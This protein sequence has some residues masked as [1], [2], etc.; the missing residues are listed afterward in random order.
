MGPGLSLGLSLGLA[1]GFGIG[2]GYVRVR[3]GTLT[4]T[5]QEEAAGGTAP[6]DGFLVE[7]LTAI[8]VFVGLVLAGAANTARV[9]HRRSRRGGDAQRG[10]GLKLPRRRPLGAGSNPDMSPDPTPKAGVG[11][12]EGRRPAV[13]VGS[14]PDATCSVGGVGHHDGRG[15][16]T[17]RSMSG[18]ASATELTLNPNPDP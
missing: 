11:R 8:G 18:S 9:Y 15:A 3:V 6:L 1:F 4:L 14:S 7:L 16:G 13:G 10:R 2:L 12:H 17:Q 5:A